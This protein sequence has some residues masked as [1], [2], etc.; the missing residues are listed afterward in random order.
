[1]EYKNFT[2][3]FGSYVFNDKVMK[4]RLPEDIYKTLKETISNGTPLDTHI[5]EVVAD[6]MKNWAIENGATHYTH[7]FQPLNGFTAEKHDSFLS[8]DKTGQVAIA[9]F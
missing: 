5:A 6:A 8:I 3:C 4:S 1:M 9:E 2:D 7:W